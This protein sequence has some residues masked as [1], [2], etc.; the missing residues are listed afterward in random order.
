MPYHNVSNFFITAKHTIEQTIDLINRNGKGIALVTDE[1]HHLLGTITDGDIRRAILARYALNQPV[2]ALLEIKKQPPYKSN[3]PI[4]APQGTIPAKLLYLMKEHSIRHIPLVSKE[5]EIVDLVTWD[6]LIPDGAP[7]MQAVIM[8]GG[9]GTRLRPLTEDLP[10]PM[11]PVDGQP[12]MAHIVAQLKEAGIRSINVTTHYKAE[13][14]KA[15]FGGGEAFGVQINYVNEEQPLGTGGALGLMPT[16]DNPLLVI[17]GDILTQMDFRAMLAFHKENNADMTIA[18]RRYDVQVPYGLVECEGQ[19]VRCLKEK[20][21]LDFL[22][23]AGIYLLEPSVFRLIPRGSQFNMTDL[24]QWLLDARRNVVSFLIHE[25][26]LDIGQ[27]SD[28]E[29]AQSAFKS[30]TLKEKE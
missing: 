4:T 8:A 20:P 19:R 25:F 27:L 18:V 9:Q 2:S 22:V 24:I 6:D 12:L 7:P 15:Y 16:P 5:G 28:Y 29:L 23:N 13:K 1:A 14:I 21:Q 17:N 30:K 11:L 10:K 3:Q 26:W